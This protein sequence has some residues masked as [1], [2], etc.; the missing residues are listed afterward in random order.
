MN[1]RLA[2]LALLLAA[3]C[4]REREPRPQWIVHVS[5]DAPLPQFGDRIRIDV[6]DASGAACVRCTEVFDIQ[7]G[8]KLPLSFGVVAST[9][10]RWVRARLFRA[11]NTGSDGTP[12]EPLID[13]LGELPPLEKAPLDVKLTLGMDCFGK[14]A[15][16]DTK[17]GCDPATGSV[18]SGLRAVAGT[19]TDLP[20][21]GSWGNGIEPCAGEAPSEMVCVPGGVFLLGSRQYVP[22]GADFDPVPEQLVHVMP[23]F[24]DADEMTVGALRPLVGTLSPPIVMD[25]THPYC[26]YTLVPGANEAMS[27]SCVDR[28]EA[29]AACA[30]QGKRLPTEAE[31]ELSAGAG[32]LERPYPFELGTDASSDAI[33]SSAV[34]ARADLK[35]A[36]GSRQCILIDDYP[37]GPQPGGSESDLNPLGL[38][39]MGGNLAEWVADD[40][41]AFADP[42][43]WGPVV[44]LKSSPRCVDDP[45]LGVL[46]GG[47]WVS[48]TYNTHSF[49]RRSAPST[50]KLPFVGFRCAKDAQ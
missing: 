46:K 16:L 27:V 15:D 8:E 37:V 45:A 34:V 4:H 29:E 11:E 40:F 49:F 35:D 22:F 38:R 17:S 9:A 24:I 20:K 30:A 28:A 43:C 13:Y 19:G 26:T 42:T 6:L 3:A 31:W 7:G 21:P 25:P 33:C 10:K 23:Y 47:S 41:A 48:V 1:R 18:S 14:P 39:N 50:L 2:P 44:A 36:T 32:S 5:T 12:S